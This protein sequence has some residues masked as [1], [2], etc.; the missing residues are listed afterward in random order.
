M[1]KR[2]QTIVF[3]IVRSKDSLN[4]EIIEYYGMRQKNKKD[5]ANDLRQNKS[6]LI[7]ELKKQFKSL[8]TCKYITVE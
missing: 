5:I 3:Q 1:Y 4:C 8:H 2:G 6:F 7:A